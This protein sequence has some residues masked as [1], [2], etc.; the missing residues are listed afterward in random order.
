MSESSEG[1]ACLAPDNFELFKNS[2]LYLK[3]MSL[4]LASSNVDCLDFFTVSETELEKLKHALKLLSESEKQLRVSSERSTWFTAT[5]L[6]L[7]SVTSPEFTLS[8][9]SKKQSSKTTEED[10]STASRDASGRKQTS[11]SLYM[12]R[13]SAS[14]LLS[15]EG[16]QNSGYPEGPYLLTGGMNSNSKATHKR[17]VNSLD[18][19]ASHGDFIGGS[20][21][22]GQTNMDGLDDIWLQCIERCHSKTL[23]QL[24]HSHGRLLSIAEAEGM[25]VI[26]ICRFNCFDHLYVKLGDVFNLH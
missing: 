10:P 20:L 5:L 8:G 21:N 23:R 3:T 16:N 12:I 19:T 24:L 26:S 15:A 7:G 9:S 1:S 4:S 17:S 25:Y 13:R 2:A 11:D 6:Q 14:P 22:T 18:S